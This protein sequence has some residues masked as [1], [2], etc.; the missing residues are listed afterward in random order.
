MVEQLRKAIRDS[1]LSLNEL[2]KRSGVAVPQL[3]RFVRG[4]RD[5]TL[6]T[7]E[8]VCEALGLHLGPERIE[9]Q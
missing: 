2:G 6:S 8:K 1:G 4:E 5:L 7:A 9:Y 3:S